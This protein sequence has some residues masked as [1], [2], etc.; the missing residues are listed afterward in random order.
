MIGTGDGTTNHKQTSKAVKS[1]HKTRMPT[2]MKAGKSKS[3]YSPNK[4]STQA[5]KDDLFAQNENSLI[6]VN[7]CANFN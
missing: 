3:L 4:L 6:D 7:N 1:P 5:S 2:A